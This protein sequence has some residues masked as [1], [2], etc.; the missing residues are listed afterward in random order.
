MIIFLDCYATIYGKK[1]YSFFADSFTFNAALLYDPIK[2]ILFIL[3][4][5]L[6]AT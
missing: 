2:Y 6:N 3:E 5:L 4:I 1:T